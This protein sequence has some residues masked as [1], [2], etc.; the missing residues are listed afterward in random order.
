M[1]S[2]VADAPGCSVNDIAVATMTDRSSAAA[3]VERLAARGL[4]VRTRAAD[5]RR[6]AAVT[7]SASG[8][9]AL[10]RAAPPPTAILVAALR[11]LPAA[12]LRQLS[13]ALAELTD[14]MGIADQP[15][16]MLFEETARPK[17]KTARAAKRRRSAR[18]QRQ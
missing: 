4:V 14:A 5:D 2:A 9:R 16:G 17:A 18:V 1:L 3:V 13:T 10:G 8:R 7:L 15:P 6:R 12:R 11:A